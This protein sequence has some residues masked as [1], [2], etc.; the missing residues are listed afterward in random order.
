[1]IVGE[2]VDG[3]MKDGEE[4]DVLLGLGR[5]CLRVWVGRRYIGFIAWG[6]LSTSY[7]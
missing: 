7:W 3:C 1:M 2:L 4:S 6:C 5:C